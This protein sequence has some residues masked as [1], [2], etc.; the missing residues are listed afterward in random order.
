MCIEQ[1]KE[2]PLLGILRGIDEASVLPLSEVIISSGLKV[3]EVTMNTP[4]AGLLIKRF[5]AVSKNRFSVGAG[6]VLSMEQLAAALEF[7]AEFIVMPIVHK[8]AVLHC[9]KNKIPVFPGALTPNEIF[10]A[11]TLGAAMVKVFPAKIF[12][13]SYFNEIKAPLSDV[14]LLACG[15]ITT[16]NI[17]EYIDN[18]ADAAA[19]G[20]SIFKKEWI[21]NRQFALIEQ[22]I[23]ELIIALPKRTK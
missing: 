2:V 5:K 17:A 13:P 9:V 20:T 7:G 4:S 19:F 12:G 18:G 21:K 14:K 3:I 22:M 16:K 11:W 6:T 15:G 10:T 1:F 23:K 8:E